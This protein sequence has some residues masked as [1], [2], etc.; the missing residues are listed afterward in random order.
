MDSTSNTLDACVGFAT[1]CSLRAFIS[2]VSALIVLSPPPLSNDPVMRLALSLDHQAVIGELKN[3]NNLV[4]SRSLPGISAFP[5]KLVSRCRNPAHNNT[6]TYPPDL[7]LL[8]P[9]MREEL[10]TILSRPVPLSPEA[11][12][13]TLMDVSDQ[14]SSSSRYFALYACHMLSFS[15]CPDLHGYLLGVSQQGR[16]KSP[17]FC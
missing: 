4:H 5:P 10:K 11:E 7:S 14:S 8:T 9:D 15:K 13:E 3:S 1:P 2:A 17:I 6:E 16:S 12:T